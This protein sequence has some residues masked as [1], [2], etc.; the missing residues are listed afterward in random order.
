MTS[1]VYLMKIEEDNDSKRKIGKSNNPSGQK[2]GRARVDV[3]THATHRTLVVEEV[4]ELDSESE[5][6][7]LEEDLRNRYA[8]RRI[9]DENPM[10]KWYDLEGKLDEVKRAC[11]KRS[12]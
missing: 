9:N 4:Y 3:L 7:N 8:S 12:N 5:A 11:E 2:D 10:G 6:E 1:Y